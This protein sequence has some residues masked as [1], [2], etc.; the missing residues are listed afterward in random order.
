MSGKELAEGYVEK[1]QATSQVTPNPDSATERNSE[2]PIC[3]RNL[4]EDDIDYVDASYNIEKEIALYWPRVRTRINNLNVMTLREANRHQE[5]PLARIKK[6]MKLDEDVR[7]QMISAEAPVLLAKAAELFIE[8]LALRS[9]LH[10]EENKRKTLQKCDISQAVSRYDQFDFLI[11]IVPRD[12]KRCQQVNKFEKIIAPTSSASIESEIIDCKGFSQQNGNNNSV[13][14]V[15][16]VGPSEG[17]IT[18]GSMV[19]ATPIGQPIQ[20]P[21]APGGQPIQLITLGLPDGNV[22][23]FQVQL[24]TA[25]S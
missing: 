23:Q 8:E 17:A 6:I 18:S 15:L 10:T 11:D 4:D 19:Q 22:Q 25:N 14:Y 21:I 2:T 3:S 7:H 1:M 5:L 20:L 16:Q 12:E 13:Q 24:P 9:W